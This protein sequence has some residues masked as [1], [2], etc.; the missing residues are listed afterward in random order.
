[1][2]GVGTGLTAKNAHAAVSSKY[3]FV[4]VFKFDVLTCI[5]TWMKF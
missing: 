3:V 4:V 2:W 1:M 5:G